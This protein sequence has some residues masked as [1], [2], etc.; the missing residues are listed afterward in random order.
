MTDVSTMADPIRTTTSAPV[1]SRAAGRSWWLAIGAVFA[2]LVLGLGA[3]SL[4][5]WLALRTETQHQTYDHAITRLVIDGGTGDLTFSRGESSSVVVDRRLTWSFWKPEI[6]ETWEGETLRVTTRCP[7]INAG[8][9]C[10]VDYVIALPDGVDVEA[11]TGT[12]DVSVSDLRGDVRVTTGTGDITAAGL[13]ST[14]VDVQSGTGDVTLRF[15]N[16]PRTVQ[17]DTGTGNV[18]ITVPPGDLYQVNGDSGTGD[19]RVRL[20]HDPSASRQITV[21]TGTGDI[22]VSYS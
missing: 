7:P 16:A 11:Y 5:S 2:V 15:G 14:D 17:A 6:T 12:G 18:R 10:S 13:T 22:D 3:F 19:L 1:T 20:V 8:P 21:H 4:A 9:N